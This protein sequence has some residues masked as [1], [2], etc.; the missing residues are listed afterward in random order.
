MNRNKYT[1][2]IYDFLWFLKQKKIG[3]KI[4]DCGAGGRYPKL[5]L[6]AKYG[7]NELY[8]IDISED[9]LESASQF[10]KKNN[11]KMNLQKANMKE[12]PFEDN[13][14]D[15]IYS[16][17][18]IFHMTKKDI[19]QAVDEMIRVLKPGGIGFI[20]FLDV[21]DDI[22]KGTNEQAP[23]EYV[24]IHDGEKMIHTLLTEDECE[25]MLKDVI[26]LEKQKKYIHRLELD[27]KYKFGFLDY[28]F[29]KK[30]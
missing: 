18:T 21:D 3:K 14:F 2:E 17:N 10:A 20:N 1:T 8:G 24:E 4:L 19:H 28:F 6:L 16:Y 5:A 23:G 22:H 12:I 30:K 15:A 27:S 9:S 13:F 25:L 7:Y 26:I 29:Q 11:I